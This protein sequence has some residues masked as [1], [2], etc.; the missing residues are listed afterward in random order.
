MDFRTLFTFCG[1]QV[2]SSLIALTLPHF[3]SLIFYLTTPFPSL[4][5]ILSPL[6]LGG[7]GLRL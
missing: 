6:P 7:A 1:S 2:S 5:L 3:L 4:S